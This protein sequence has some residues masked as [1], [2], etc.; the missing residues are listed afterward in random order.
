MTCTPRCPIGLGRVAADR[1]R[2]VLRPVRGDPERP[3]DDGLRAVRADDD[4]RREHAVHLDVRPAR[5]SIRRTVCRR[6]S[7][8]GASA[9][10]SSRASNTARGTTRAG[11]CIAALDRRPR[12]ATA[13]AAAA[14]PD[15]PRS[16]RRGRRRA[17]RA[18][19][20]PRGR[21]RRRTP[22]R[23]GSR[24]GRASGPS[25]RPRARRE[26]GGRPGRAAADDDDVP[27]LH[28]GNAR[29]RAQ[30]PAG[31]ATPSRGWESS[32][33]SCPGRAPRARWSR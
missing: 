6:S 13:A 4:A 10:S 27:V 5:T 22:C 15:S 19:P 14:R 30:C 33:A 12:P 17:R 11:R 8:P 20:A 24:P 31:F 26:R 9:A 7:A 16:A 23:G 1:D 3:A 21:C 2:R 18:R 29:Q 25:R 28:G 32:P